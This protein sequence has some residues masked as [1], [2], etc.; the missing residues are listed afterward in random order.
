MTSKKSIMYAK[1]TIVPIG[2]I[3][4]IYFLFIHGLTLQKT[5]NRSY[6]PYSLEEDDKQELITYIGSTTGEIEIIKKC[7]MFTCNK[8]S[9]HK[10]NALKNKEA[11][12]IGYAQYSSAILNYAFFYK[13]LSSK[14]RP[15]V[16]QVY[17]YGLNIHPFT[18]IILPKNLKSFFKD[19][20][21]VE[22]QKENGE[23]IFIDTSLQDL[24]GKSFLN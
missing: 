17:L 8:L 3:G 11:N 6:I 13:G 22:I 12:C 21:F 16:G 1:R 7:S 20:D 15:I 9:F 18:M 10:K 24:I 2:I 5:A 19:H 14:A 4:T 23:T